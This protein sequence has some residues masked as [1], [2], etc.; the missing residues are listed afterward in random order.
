MERIR[1]F[2]E[3]K[4][5]RRSL[6]YYA[7]FICLGMSVTIIGPTLPAL[8]AQTGTRL[9]L[10]GTMF[11]F[12]SI[13]YGAGTLLG[14]RIL[15]QLQG[16]KVLATAALT[17]AV[18]LGLYPLVD[19]YPVLL[20]IVLLKGV[21]DGV[22][23]T[24]ANTLVVW[25]HADN[26]APYLTALHFFFGGGAF[27][28]PLLLAWILNMGTPYGVI[29]WLLTALGLLS[30]IPLML[31]PHHPQTAAGSEALPA[32]CRQLKPYISIV[33]L[34]TSFLFF[35]VGAELTLGGWISSVAILLQMAGHAGAAVLTSGFFMA[36]TIG[37]LIAI[38][39]ASRFSERELITAALA[40]CLV[41]L[42]VALMLLQQ[43]WVVWAVALGTGFFMAPLYPAGLS[44]AGKLMPLSARANSIILMGD[45]MGA[46]LLPSVAGIIIE[47]TSP[48]SM[49]YLVA[50]SLIL[51]TLIF[52]L[53]LRCTP[54]RAEEP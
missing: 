14:G 39:A 44:L 37:R 16:S 53:L 46:M 27:L 48:L 4:S 28:S 9:G 8:A 47:K 13:G 17:S 1:S 54:V 33:V 15:D 52:H 3:R 43:P 20:A 35:Y 41:I 5:N 24:S 10:M 34:S 32:G 36:F 2:L 6:N 51:A 38:P 18:L 45:S 40:G 26:A 49:L 31:D 19:K 22:L 50:G 30:A 29:F 25:T 11:L 23:N 12:S 42:A 21:S 7:V